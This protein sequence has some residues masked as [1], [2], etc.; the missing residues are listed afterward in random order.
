MKAARAL[1]A[2]AVATALWLAAL[3]PVFR[4]APSRWL[5]AEGVSPAVRKLA[6]RH[7]LLWSDPALRAGEIGRMRGTNAEWD[8]MGRTFVVLSLANLCLQEPDRSGEY[9]AAA[10]RIIEDTLA[11]ERELGPLHFLMPYAR[12]RPFVAEPP[13]SLFVDGEIAL[14]LA[15]RRLA[16]E[17]DAY[18]SLLA[19]RVDAIDR[20]MRTG[21]I[22]CAE[23]YP[24]EC[25]IFCNAAA[26][27]ALKLT[28]RLDG[29]NHTPLFDAWKEKAKM[30]LTDESTGLLISS[31][32]LD[33]SRID[34][35][36]GSSI[37]MAAHCLQLWDHDW[38]EELYR[39]ARNELGRTLLGFG[40]AREWPVHL[41]GPVDVDSGAVIPMLGLSPASSGLALLGAA[42][43]GDT[44]YLLRLIASLRFGGMPVERNGTLRFA[45]GNQVG[46]AVLLY[47]LVQGPLWAKAS[48][49]RE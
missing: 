37:W 34:G 15:A 5:S 26:L 7:L 49:A 13:R 11:A 36:E 21:P 17:K 14:M 18:R 20:A 16:A 6:A 9:L 47:A 25:W 33:G 23:S 30:R 8:F 41:E 42:S 4:P 29:T 45:A 48:E 31:F 3:Y 24:D 35:P 28:D 39:R 40:Y 38:A 27:A 12:Y 1:C 44:D 19:E 10:D 2:L 32:T 46:D 43:F 22:L